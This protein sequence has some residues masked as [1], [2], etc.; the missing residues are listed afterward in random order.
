MYSPRER[1]LVRTDLGLGEVDGLFDIG[2][3]FTR[4]TTF[5][6]SSFKLS[7]IMGAI[8]SL[9]TTIASGGLVAFAPKIQSAHS[10]VSKIVGIGTT[11]VAAVAGGAALLPAGTL[12]SVGSAIGTGLKT[13]A[14]VLPVAGK[15]F[16]GGGGQQQQQSG[17]DPYA[18]QYVQQYQ[19][20]QAIQAQQA[21]AEQAAYVKAQQEAMYQPGG[22][23]PSI[24]YTTQSYPGSPTMNTSYGD[25]RTPY[26]A[27]TENG[28]QVQVDPATGQVIP[29][30]NM[31]LLIG[32]GA[33]ALILGWYL[34]SD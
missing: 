7:N 34:L 22:Y 29:D 25:L 18:Q 8:G 19:T 5:T 33:L 2:K 10:D 9:T 4:L 15:M 13:I 31:P 32:G 24:P 12:A 6:P 1:G 23:A 14:Q 30:N 28:E 20:A 16:S 11:A 26:T 21:A 17:V 3:M 27:I